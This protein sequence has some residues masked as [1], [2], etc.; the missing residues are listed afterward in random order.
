MKA[1]IPLDEFTEEVIGSGDQSMGGR[2]MNN[3]AI[4]NAKPDNYKPSKNDMLPPSASLDLEYVFG[5]RCHDTRNNLRYASDG[6]LVYHT[7]AVGIVMDAA[8]NT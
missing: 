5:Y 2:H 3:G 8:T 4:K 7:A 1:D 6:K